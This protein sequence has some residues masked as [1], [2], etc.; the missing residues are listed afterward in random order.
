MSRISAGMAM[1]LLACLA[2]DAAA[3]GLLW[4]LPEDETAWV[5]YEGT[6]K[7]LVRRPQATEGD[8]NVE[9][10]KHLTIK[11]IKSVEV[12]GRKCRWLEFKVVTGNVR[13]GI[14]DTGP[15]GAKLYA[16]L[17]PE[18]EIRGSVEAPLDEERT[19]FVEYVPIVNGFRKIG[20]EDAQPIT[21]PVFQV[22]PVI[23]LLRHYRNLAGSGE[24]SI[25]GV[26]A[27]RYTGSITMETPSR[28]STNTAEIW[29]SEETPFG[30][31][32]WTASTTAEEKGT[33]AI[34]SEFQPLSEFSEEMTLAETGVGAE[35]E[36]LELQQLLTQ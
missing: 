9:W 12:D 8:L 36:L 17:V 29:R 32:K 27:V 31:V 14:I 35:S 21:G 30:V 33:T 19:V 23:A 28:R 6:Y 2:T 26:T 1:A 11:S 16:V 34:R 22:Y 24:E 25:G 13:D 15:G 20:D 18:E 5:R 7:Q 10:T 3:Q 4:K